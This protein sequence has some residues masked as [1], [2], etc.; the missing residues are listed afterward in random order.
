MDAQSLWVAFRKLGAQ[1]SLAD[2]N[3]LVRQLD[4]DKTGKISFGE[5][6]IRQPKVKKDLIGGLASYW[7][8]AKLKSLTSYELSTSVEE[9]DRARNVTD[10]PVLERIAGVMIEARAASSQ[11]PAHV[12]H[13]P[14]RH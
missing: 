4:K 14:Y 9:L 6:V 12:K 13:K 10:R 1:F 3:A 2:R 7:S 5:F 11:F 8:I